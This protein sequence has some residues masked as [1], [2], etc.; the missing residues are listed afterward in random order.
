MNDERKDFW[1][2]IFRIEYD[3]IIIIVLC[4]FFLSTMSNTGTHNYA[5]E[6]SF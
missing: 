2:S 6:I 5:F 1:K 3:I 4:N